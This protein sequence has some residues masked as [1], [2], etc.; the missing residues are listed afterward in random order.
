MF[1][2]FAL[3]LIVLPAV[4]TAQERT[5]DDLFTWSGRLAAGSTLGIKHFNGPIEVRE[6]TGDRVEFRAE[7]R[8]RRSNELSFEVQNESDGVTLCSVWR[9]R[10]W[11]WDDGPPSSRLTVM[12]PK[13]IRLR[14]TTGNGD[15]TVEKASNDVEIRSGNGD[16]RITLKR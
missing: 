6:A 1:R 13:G 15:V 9:G 12:L 5:S 11:D 16:V 14:A 8:S 4:L 3:S 2:G 7:R 10:N